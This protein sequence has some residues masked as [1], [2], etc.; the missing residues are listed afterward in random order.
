AA[1]VNP[2]RLL[3]RAMNN[4]ALRNFGHG[5]LSVDGLGAASRGGIRTGSWVKRCCWLWGLKPSDFIFQLH[6]VGLS[7]DQIIPKPFRGPLLYLRPYHRISIHFEYLAPLLFPQFTFP[8]N[9]VP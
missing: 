2:P 9:F 4:L 6:D 1:T 8:I 7:L 5:R 3:A